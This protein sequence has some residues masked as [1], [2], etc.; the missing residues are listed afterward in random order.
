MLH[1][2]HRVEELE[3]AALGRRCADALGGHFSTVDFLEHHTPRKPL[4][5]H[6]FRTGEVRPELVEEDVW[7]QGRVEPAQVLI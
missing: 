3:E 5:F 4:L 6:A 2:E 1:P 7:L